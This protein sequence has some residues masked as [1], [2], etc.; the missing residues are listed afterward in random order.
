MI[1]G[2]TADTFNQGCFGGFLLLL[3]GEEED[4]RTDRLLEEEELFP[5]DPLP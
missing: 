1:P 2:N 4:F 3:E 5:T